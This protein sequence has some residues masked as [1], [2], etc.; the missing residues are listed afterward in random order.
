MDH[1]PKCKALKYKTPRKYHGHSADGLRYNTKDMI[2][3]G[4]KDMLGFIK[5]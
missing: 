4:K 2:H 3:G 5:I 1:R